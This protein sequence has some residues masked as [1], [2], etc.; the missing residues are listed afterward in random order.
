LFTLEL[1]RDA[2]V[3]AQVSCFCQSRF[4]TTPVGDGRG[5]GPAVVAAIKSK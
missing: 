3:P 1:L 5:A 2:P 4:I